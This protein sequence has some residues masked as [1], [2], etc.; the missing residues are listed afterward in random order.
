MGRLVKL[1]GSGIGMAS[2]AIHDYRARSQDGKSSPN[3]AAGPSSAAATYGSDAPPGYYEVVDDATAE[4]LVR[5]GKAEMVADSGEKSGRSKASYA[6]YSDEDD[7]SSDD[8]GDSGGSRAAADEAI[9][10]LDDMAEQVA[11][12]AYSGSDSPPAYEA[13]SEEE[14]IKKEEMMIRDLVRMAGP[15]PRPAQRLPCPVIIPQRRPR[16]KGRGFVRAYAPVLND[17]GIG[18]DVF[19]RFLKDWYMAS[20]VC[21]LSTHCHSLVE[22]V[23]LTRPSGLPVGPL[24]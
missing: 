20:K 12:N 5:S 6:G 19:L 23:V 9:W 3:P 14:M 18:Q 21:R 8:D 10:E 24:D 13:A 22:L 17:C 4:R 2:E 15:P 11:P 7:S 1:L 16:N